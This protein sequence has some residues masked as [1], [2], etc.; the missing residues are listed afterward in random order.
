MH[1]FDT[2]YSTKEAM[3]YAKENNLEIVEEFEGCIY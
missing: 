3:E 1:A 2:H